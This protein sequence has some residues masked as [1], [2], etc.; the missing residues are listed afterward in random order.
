MIHSSSMIQIKYSWKTCPSQRKKISIIS[1]TPRPL[2]YKKLYLKI[3]YQYNKV[4]NTFWQ[5][6]RFLKSSIKLGNYMMSNVH[7]IPNTLLTE[8][9]ISTL[10]TIN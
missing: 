7:S 9:E 3:P 2:S 6:T 4:Q 8:N 1:C 10:P 5:E